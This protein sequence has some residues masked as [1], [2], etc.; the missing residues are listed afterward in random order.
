RRRG[1]TPD[2]C[3]SDRRSKS[4][5]RKQTVP[6]PVSKRGVGQTKGKHRL[7]PIQIQSELQRMMVCGPLGPSRITAGDTQHRCFSCFKPT[8][9]ML[10]SPACIDKIAFLE[11]LFR[12]RK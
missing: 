1:G 11:S 10:S 9:G 2:Q 12:F 3:M 7:I 8:V 6:A 4:S 5:G